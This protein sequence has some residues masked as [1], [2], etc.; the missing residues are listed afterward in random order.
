MKSSNNLQL[1]CLNE[2]NL[3]LLKKYSEKY[4]LRNLK[5]LL[6]LTFIETQAEE[7]YEKLEPWIQWPSVY[8]G[9]DSDNHGVFRLGGMKNC[10][11]PQI[12]RSLRGR[13]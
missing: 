4:D 8:T 7:T 9:L 13:D 10:D 11:E 12:L 1:I 5:K 6:A 2:L 3:D